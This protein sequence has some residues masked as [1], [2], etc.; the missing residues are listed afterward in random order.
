MEKKH[1]QNNNG[2]STSRTTS[3][4]KNQR[5]WI[6][7]NWTNNFNHYFH[8]LIVFCV[9]LIINFYSMMQLNLTF[10]PHKTWENLNEKS[11]VNTISIANVLCI[12]IPIN[13]LLDMYIDVCAC[14]NTL[15]S[16]YLLCVYSFLILECNILYFRL[17]NMQT[18]LKNLTIW[19]QWCVCVTLLPA[20]SLLVMLPSSIVNA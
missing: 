4:P 17:E 7:F 5:V 3:I 20:T 19:N 13:R 18:K 12:Q 8:S 9:Y 14:L 11:G 16:R 15:C 6:I 10:Y 2:Q 1:S